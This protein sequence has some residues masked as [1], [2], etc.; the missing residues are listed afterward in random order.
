[1]YTIDL[2]NSL[3]RRKNILKNPV[4]NLNTE[5]L[6]EYLEIQGSLFFH[7]NHKMMIISDVY[8]LSF[9]NSIFWFNN[10]EYKNGSEI[11]A[12]FWED[13]GHRI[14]IHFN[15]E[16]VKVVNRKSI[17]RESIEI[18][19]KIFEKQISICLKTIN[20]YVVIS[21]GEI[22]REPVFYKDLKLRSNFTK[23]K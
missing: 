1:M 4:F 12:Y 5:Q 7:N 14:D 17:E 21:Y 15:E 23:F 11:N 9:L 3:F 19:R 13:H 18:N 16:I 22:I 6:Y 2:E 10:T 8:G 20:D